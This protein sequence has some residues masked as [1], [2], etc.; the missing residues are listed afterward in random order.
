MKIRDV[1]E[2]VIPHLTVNRS[3]NEGEQAKIF[4]GYSIPLRLIWQDIIE[5]CH[6]LAKI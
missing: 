3:N 2:Y 4:I 5:S 6:I 1:L